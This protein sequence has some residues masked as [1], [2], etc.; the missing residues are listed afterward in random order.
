M[1]RTLTI[2]VG[3]IGILITLGVYYITIASLIKLFL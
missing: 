2:I 3:W 1:K